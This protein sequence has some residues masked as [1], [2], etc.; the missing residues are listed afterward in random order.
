MLV[1]LRFVSATDQLPWRT[2]VFVIDAKDIKGKVRVAKPLFPLP[3]R[4]SGANG[5]MLIHQSPAF[6]QRESA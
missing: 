6:R 2:G 4:S 1:Q 3:D 5:T